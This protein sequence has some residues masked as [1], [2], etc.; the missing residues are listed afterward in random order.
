MEFYYEIEYNSNIL[1]LLQRNL[2]NYKVVYL[3]NI[4]Q[5]TNLKDFYLSL[6]NNLELGEVILNYED[7]KT[8]E[9]IS[10]KWL[11]IKYVENMSNQS[12]RFSNQKHPLHTDGA[13]T[14]FWFDIGFLI[15]VEQ[16]ESGGETIFLD[17]EL[18]CKKLKEYDKHLYERLTNESVL[19]KKNEQETKEAS[20][21]HFNNNG[22]LVINWNYRRISENNN[23]ASLKLAENFNHFIH[24]R[25]GVQQLQELRL[26]KGEAVFFHDKKVLHGR[27][28][29]NGD[30]FLLKGGIRLTN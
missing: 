17:G 23:R 25:I 18:L 2:V 27:Y 30:R 6:L 9:M 1:H 26:E 28:H 24:E 8:G 22:E 14:D 16:A 7:H 19:F 13:Y 15:C 4:D 10:N 29:F 12:L 5:S 20:I 3:K 21:L 11:G